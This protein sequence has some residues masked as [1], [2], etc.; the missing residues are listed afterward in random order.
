MVRIVFFQCQLRFY[1]EPWKNR[2]YLVSKGIFWHKKNWHAFISFCVILPKQLFQEISMGF[3]WNILPSSL[4]KHQETLSLV[5]V[6][7]CGSMNWCQYSK[8]KNSVLG[9]SQYSHPGATIERTT[10]FQPSNSGM[11]SRLTIL[12]YTHGACTMT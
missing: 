2:S 8:E 6:L 3:T 7:E 1:S 12:P 9:I 5:S 11:F 4:R 10:M